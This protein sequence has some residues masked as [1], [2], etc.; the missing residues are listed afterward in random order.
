MK[1]ETLLTKEDLKRCKQLTLK[2][3]KIVFNEEEECRYVSIVLQGTIQIVSYSL[4][5]R[6][7]IY[8]EISENGLF[9]NN[10]LFSEKPYYKGNVIAKTDAKIL[11]INKENLIKILQNNGEFLVFY[12]STQAEFSKK[13]NGT[14]KLLSFA[15]AEER[16]M[17][18]LKENSPLKIKSI[19][20]LAGQ[21]FLTRETLSRLVSKLKKEGKIEQKDNVLIL[22]N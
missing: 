20:S 6:E 12:L 17:Y 21:L 2:K 11:L 7:I 5:G 3:G 22:K 9:G 13:L 18:F 16:L 1:I 8:N 10:L 4:S 19:S 14:I 15:S